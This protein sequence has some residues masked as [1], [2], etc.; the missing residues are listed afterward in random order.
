MIYPQRLSPTGVETL[1]LADGR[2]VHVPKVTPSFQ[3]WPGPAPSDTFGKKPVLDFNG[4]PAFAELVVLW[5][6]LEA[7]WDGVWIDSYRRR[8]L[9]DFWPL[10]VSQEVPAEQ[11]ELLRKIAELATVPAK[12]WDVLCWSPAGVIFGEA[13][14]RRRDSVRGTQI[15][16][17]GAALR[18]GLPTSLFLLVEWSVA[19]LSACS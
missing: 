19:E 16:F 2:V 3:A 5:N 13:K 6:F 9:R 17:L 7:G 14:R 11:Q 18:F 4:R 10:P 15:E 12:P 1:T 8:F